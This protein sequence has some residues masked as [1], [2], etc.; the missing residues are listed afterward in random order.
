[1]YGRTT[2]EYVEWYQLAA[3]Q[4]EINPYKQIRDNNI[5]TFN[6]KKHIIEIRKAIT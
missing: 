3:F 1:M 5:S 2:T 4:I 6:K